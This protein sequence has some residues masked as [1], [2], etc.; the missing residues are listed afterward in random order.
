[1]GTNRGNL[2][3]LICSSS[4]V[5][6]RADGGKQLGGSRS[7]RRRTPPPQTECA[8]DGDGTGRKEVCIRSVKD[9]TL[10]KA[11]RRFFIRAHTLKTTQSNS[12]DVL[13]FAS[14]SFGLRRH[15]NNPHPLMKACVCVC[16]CV[17]S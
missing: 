5:P 17:V 8:A 14:A 15:V 6:P 13:R 16:V 9:V 7:P 11:S 2:I 3:K 4:D 1:M 10:T 12:Q